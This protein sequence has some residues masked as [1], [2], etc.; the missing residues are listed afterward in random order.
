MNAD[1]SNQTNLTSHPGDDTAPTF[2]A[3]G[4]HVAFMSDREGDYDVWV[5]SL[6][7]ARPST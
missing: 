1:G 4:L 5:Q 2:S 6:A 7:A 3:D